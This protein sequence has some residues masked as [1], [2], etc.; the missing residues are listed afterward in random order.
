[1]YFGERN[2]INEVRQALPMSLAQL[3]VKINA[4]HEATEKAAQASIQHARAAGDMLR[5]AKA[6]VGHGNWLPWLEQHC[7]FSRRTAQTYMKIADRWDELTNGER[8]PELLSVREGLRLLANPGEDASDHDAL[9][10]DGQLCLRMGEISETAAVD[11]QRLQIYNR[12]A[13][14]RPLGEFMSDE[15]QD[16]MPSH[17]TW[18]DHMAKLILWRPRYART[19]EAITFEVDSALYDLLCL[20]VEYDPLSEE[21]AD[22][23][24]ERN[25]QNP[26]A[27][28]HGLD[29][30]YY[31]AKLWT[32]MRPDFSR[33]TTEDRA[34]LKEAAERYLNRHESAA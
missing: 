5:K 33:L 2:S 30:D 10:W 16:D 31:W 25:S 27:N 11:L 13:T 12:L 18:A 20:L 9:P 29:P 14:R 19:D 24:A 1:M 34:L 15:D 6:T 26:D 23:L 8:A 3:A 4:E 22:A 28:E 21:A 32:R 17:R 7:Q